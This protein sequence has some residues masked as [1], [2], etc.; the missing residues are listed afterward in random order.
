MRDSRAPHRPV[1]RPGRGSRSVGRRTVAAAVVTAAV[2]GAPFVGAPSAMA[3]KRA[4]V[5]ASGVVR[6][7][8]TLVGAA[9]GGLHLDPAKSATPEFDYTW[10]VAIY[11]SLLR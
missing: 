9:A 8:T 2:V 11:D 6:I 5:D 1:A 7:A 4:A 3:V 10:Q